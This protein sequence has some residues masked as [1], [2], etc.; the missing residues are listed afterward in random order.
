M[1]DAGKLEDPC[2][3]TNDNNTK[4]GHPKDGCL[5]INLSQPC[6]TGRDTHKGHPVQIKEDLSGSPKGRCDSISKPELTRGK[7]VDT[8]H[9]TSPLDRSKVKPEPPFFA[10][11]I[12]ATVFSSFFFASSILCVKMQTNGNTVEEKVRSLLA[13]SLV[14]TI[15]S[16]L[17]A[18]CKRSSLKV[19]RS[20]IKSTLAR[21]VCGC[22]YYLLAYMSLRY[23]PPG[24]S[25]ALRHLSP[26]WTGFLAYAILGEP[27]HWIVPLMLPLSMVGVIL[28]AQ[29]DLLLNIPKNV[30]YF[31]PA[32][33]FSTGDDFD[34]SS[35]ELENASES[36]KGIIL[37][38]AS[39]MT[40]SLQYISLRYRKKT[41]NEASLFWFGS[42]TCAFALVIM[43]FTGFGGLPTTREWFLLILGGVCLWFGQF[44]M[45]WALFFESAST[46]SIIRT[47]DVAFNFCLSRV[48]LDDEILWTSLV[49]GAIICA[50]VVIAITHEQLKDLILSRGFYS[51]GR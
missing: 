48:F 28:I 45:T 42:F 50:V 33:S 47:L 30:D 5:H 41:S 51:V 49:G 46:V 3:Q 29:P 31:W 34:G 6:S 4:G 16:A 26:L 44:L 14:V 39:G 10:S 7:Q 13:S 25:S 11:G 43:S 15:L 1:I 8:T 40:L 2:N 21:S 38:I 12:I 22:I 23:I 32:D 9:L 19:D 37:S 24:E 18:I 27:L 36:W 35:P 17:T 20:E